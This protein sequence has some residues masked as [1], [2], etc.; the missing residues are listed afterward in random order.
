MLDLDALSAAEKANWV[1]KGATVRAGRSEQRCLISLSDGGEDATTERE[2]DLTTAA[3]FVDGGF[4]L[5]T[6]KQNV[7]WEDA[8]TILVSRDWGPAPLTAS[9]YPFVTKRLKR[10]QPLS[11]AVEVHRGAR[12]RR[13]LAV[14]S[15][16][17]TARAT[18]SAASIRGVTFFES[19][20]Y[21]PR[22]RQGW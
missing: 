6:S 9:G 11:A 19:E 22:A 18:R 8:D 10:G 3:S 16:W 7:A 12:D 5:P 21:H 4:S 13:Q 15:P 20:L 17:S 2:F 14:R 1:W